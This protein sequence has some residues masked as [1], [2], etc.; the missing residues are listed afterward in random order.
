VKDRGS[1]VCVRLHFLGCDIKE[2]EAIEAAAMSG[3]IR[4]GGR[5]REI[6]G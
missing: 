2:E 5:E 6:G 3:E 4:R 1:I